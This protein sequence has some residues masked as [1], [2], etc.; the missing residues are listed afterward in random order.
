MKVGGFPKSLPVGTQSPPAGVGDG[1]LA[2]TAEM[3]VAIDQ[4]N[5]GNP[6]SRLARLGSQA[7]A[8][9]IQGGLDAQAFVLSKS[10][11]DPTA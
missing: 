3:P 5:A 8:A 7:M 4:P 11:S 2:M 6:L 1:L 9:G 10:T